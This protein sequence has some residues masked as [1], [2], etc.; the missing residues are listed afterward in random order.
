[1]LVELSGY[2]NVSS[3]TWKLC[4]CRFNDLE[5]VELLAVFGPCSLCV[6]LAT[7]VSMVLL[8]DVLF[9]H[10]PPGASSLVDDS[11]LSGLEGHHVSSIV[12]T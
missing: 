8:V 3:V 6:Q 12:I 5:V 1:M 9:I 2:I 10:R 4:E 7:R 11:S